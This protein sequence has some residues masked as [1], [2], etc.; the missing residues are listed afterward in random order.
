MLTVS[1][2]ASLKAKARGGLALCVFVSLGQQVHSSVKGSCGVQTPTNKLSQF[3]HLTQVRAVD[4]GRV[5]KRRD[6]VHL[7]PEAQGQ[8]TRHGSRKGQA[9]WSARGDVDLWIERITLGNRNGQALWMDPCFGI[10][11]LALQDGVGKSPKNKRVV[12][13]EF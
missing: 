5:G 13:Y 1:G 9:E 6:L 12:I 11:L 10:T 3:S 2:I 4:I 8:L 7:F